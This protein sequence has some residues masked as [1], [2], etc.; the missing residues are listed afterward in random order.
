MVHLHEVPRM[1]KS[2][3]KVAQRLPG[4][5]GGGTES[6]CLVGPETVWNSE[7]GWWQC[8]HDKANVPNATDR[9]I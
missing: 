4:A 5:G 1:G 9:T 8:L 7:S 3:Q 2:E 6:W